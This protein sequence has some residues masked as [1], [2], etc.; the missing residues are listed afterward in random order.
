MIKVSGLGKSYERL[1][2][3]FKLTHRATII[4][5]EAIFVSSIIIMLVFSD[6]IFYNAS[7]RIT[8][9]V[10]GHTLV[11]YFNLPRTTGWWGGYSDNGGPIWQSEPMMEFVKNS[12]T[13]GQL[14]YWN[15]YS[16]A[17]SLGPETLV[18]QKFSLFTIIYSTLGG[19]TDV[20]NF[21]LL[22]L[23]FFSLFFVYK[24]CRLVFNSSFLVGVFSCVFFIL[25]GFSIAN[26]G[27][28]VTQAYLYLPMCIYATSLFFSY[29]STLRYLFLTLSMTMFMTCT[30]LPTTITFLVGIFIFSVG[31]LWEKCHK[32]KINVKKLSL[33]FSIYCSSMIL[34]ILLLAILY[35]PILESVFLHGTL[36]DYGDR[37]Y[38]PLAFPQAIISFFTSSHY[39]ELYNSM[40]S[41]AAS[42]SPG[43]RLFQGNTIYHMGSVAL[44]VASCSLSKISKNNYIAKICL[45]GLILILFRLFNLP[46][47][48]DVVS[49]LP[50]IGNIGAQ[51]WWA[52]ISTPLLILI[53]IGA[54][55]ITN[56]DFKIF[57]LLFVV[58]IFAY[59]VYYVH[60]EY[61]LSEPNLT[62]KESALQK[63]FFVFSTGIAAVIFIRFSKNQWLKSTLIA[64]LLVLS[65]Y[66]L[67]TDS[68]ILR[69]ERNDIFSTPSEEITFLKENAGL[70]RTMNIG[71]SGLRPELGSAFGISEITSL[72][73]SALKIYLDY[74]Y[75]AIEMEPSQSF[76][77]RGFPT[78]IMVKD[79]PSKTSY[80]WNM[81]NL[82]GV[83]YII[84]PTYYNNYITHMREN[85]FNVVFSNPSSTIFE[86]D[87]VLPRAFSIDN[88]YISEKSE[89]VYIENLN[90]VDTVD[91]SDFKNTSLL[92]TGKAEKRQLVV[93]TDNYH[94][95]WIAEINGEKVPIEIVNGLF[96]GVWVD[97]GVYTIKMNYK[98]ITLN[99][100]LSVTLISMFC[101]ILFLFFRNKL[102]DLVFSDFKKL[103][104]QK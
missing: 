47:F 3:I 101:L 58:F 76:Y 77:Y 64:S 16:A 35:F 15:P 74:F 57:P 69:L 1:R 95:N 22:A 20:Y 2:S 53:I 29:P 80:N 96:R 44:I 51:Y 43:G 54:K 45:I 60:T 98:P 39:Y 18:D 55:N 14:P 81:L 97:K 23:Y 104:G 48:G 32:E 67:L 78:L 37:K 93:L 40:E 27:S 59:S 41:K 85:G 73:Q 79:D 71:Q 91:I 52:A 50:I 30:F 17:G 9:Q 8:D 21:V 7:L 66:D 42:F 94:P 10:F 4:N 12:V 25:N 26:I 86:N 56:G 72:N 61:G 5:I 87:N 63:L 103:V 82:L 34:A 83:K 13:N 75:K 70:Y 84:V 28:N 46:I 92:L 88:K 68:K 99:M 36:D 62:F 49:F 6:V 89:G 102:D 33:I 19:G 11:D 100:S 38:F 90:H 65:A 31:L 24:I